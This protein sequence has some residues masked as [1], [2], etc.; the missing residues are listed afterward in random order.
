MR[1]NPGANPGETF[2]TVRDIGEIGADPLSLA[3]KACSIGVN[4]FAGDITV[5]VICGRVIV[6][7]AHTIPAARIA[8]S[9]TEHVGTYRIRKGRLP[10]API[11]ARA[12][13]DDI[14]AARAA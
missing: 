12:I 9:A 4:I 1:R 6:A 13:A 14:C 10:D 2:Q 7:A 8:A 11:A 3:R 5:G